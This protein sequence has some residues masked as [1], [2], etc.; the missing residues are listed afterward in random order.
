ML[1][2][3]RP[4][5]TRSFRVS[6][7]VHLAMNQM[8]S[9]AQKVTEIQASPAVK[10]RSRA[11]AIPGRARAIAELQSNDD[12]EDEEE[13]LMQ[14]HRIRRSTIAARSPGF[15]PPRLEQGLAALRRGSMMRR[16]SA[17][18]SPVPQDPP[19]PDPFDPESASK[20]RPSTVVT[21]PS[22]QMWASWRPGPAFDYAINPPIDFSAGSET[23]VMEVQQWCLKALESDAATVSLGSGEEC[24]GGGLSDIFAE[25]HPEL[26]LL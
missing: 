8:R 2:P 18:P 26:P 17:L 22:L 11:P 5:R 16:R 1:A 15:T 24:Q 13:I 21:D 25:L 20:R 6:V 12:E 10:E 23:V 4:P 7:G 3:E 9:E 14:R 19:T